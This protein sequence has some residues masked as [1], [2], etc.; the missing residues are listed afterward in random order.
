VKEVEAMYVPLR[1][2]VVLLVLLAVIILV[3][4]GA[5]AQTG[6]S[7]APAVGVVTVERRPM[8]E[9]DEFNGRIQAINSVN[10]LARV[11]A[12]L[13]KRLF[14]E[15]T[16]VKKGDLLYT[17]E[18]PPF[19][20][21][22]D[23]QKAA[24]A[25]AEAQLE[26]DNIALKRAQYLVQKDAGTQMALENAQ[27]TQ[28]TAAA[29]LKSAQAQLETAQINLDYTQVHSPIDGRI[30]RTSV[31]IG[32]VV[33][34]TSG[35]LTTVVSQDPMYVVFPIPTRQV[36]AMREQY[37]DKGGFDAL[38]IQ[39]RLPDGRIYGQTG[40][41]DFANNTIAQDTD[42]LLLRAS[43]P[44]PVLGSETV[45]GVQLR[46][47]VSDE[48]VTVLLEAVQPQQVI[49]VPRA[50]VLADPQGSFVYVVN[51]HDVALQR[52]VKLGQSTPETAAIV[53]GLK[54]GERVVVD[55]IQRVRPN[56]P[57]AP[58]PAPPPAGRSSQG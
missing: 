48:F 12:F 44:N 40:K 6:P 58:A 14:V 45:A 32:N 15:G 29:Q 30:G 8:T 38:K 24:V 16:D 20:A 42:T 2:G 17:L 53:D 37:A 46:E 4:P 27:A 57:V 26:N 13:E 3:A 54:E 25:Q 43:I 47:L 7:A 21:A 55:G 11:T 33:A 41:L 28:R 31:T 10:I 19:Q 39:L 50:A 18:Q 5:M 23:V 36:L 49:A 22:V 56:A 52:R 34:P 51:D 9:S 1:L 35:T